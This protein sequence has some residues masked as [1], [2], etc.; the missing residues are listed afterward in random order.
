MKKRDFLRPKCGQTATWRVGFAFRVASFVLRESDGGMFDSFW[1]WS[2]SSRGPEPRFGSPKSCIFCAQ[3]VVLS[4]NIG[5]LSNSAFHNICK[6]PRSF[7][8]AEN[9]SK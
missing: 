5:R 2:I 9:G 7:D 8:T 4:L 1:D 3:A 6:I